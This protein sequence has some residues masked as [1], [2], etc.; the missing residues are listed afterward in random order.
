M[1]IANPL[2]TVLINYYNDKKFLSASVESVLNQSYKNFELI[3]F[4]H[5]STDGSRDIARSY[6]DS[7]IIH[8]DAPKNLGAGSSYNLKYILPKV[9]GEYFKGFCADDIMHQDCLKILTDYIA[10]NPDKDLIF[11]NLEFVYASGR[12]SGVDWFHRYRDFSVDAK[13]IDI[14]KMFSTGG[15]NLPCPGSIYKTE[16]LQKIELD[17]SLTIREDMWFWVSSLIAGA[18]V[19]YCDEI[20]GYYRRHSYQE[21]YFDDELIEQRSRYEEAPFL[22]LFFKMK[23]VE[24]AKAIFPD[25]PYREKLRDP[26]DIRFYVAEYFL[27]SKGYKFAYDALFKMIQDDETRE[28]LESVFGFGVLEFRKLYAFRKKISFK[29]RAYTKNPKRLNVVELLYLLIRR[30]LKTTLAIISFRRLRY[31]I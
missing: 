28:R 9:H 20:V 21:S 15:N 6:N 22:S 30:C 11:G 10:Q 1:V 7:R 25:S 31:R 8:I 2:V 12:R 3:L 23:D 5:A 27:R 19:G 13:E 17:Y 16:L 4:N 29:K 24:A 14:L 18:R 26:Q